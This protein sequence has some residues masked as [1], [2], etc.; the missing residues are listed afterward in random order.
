MVIFKISC[1]HVFQV[2]VCV[3]YFIFSEIV[4]HT[5]SEIQCVFH[6]YSTCPFRLATFPGDPVPCVT[7]AIS[8]NNKAIEQ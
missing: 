3:R 8:Q 5:L 1:H 6:T 7:V 4:S 2:K